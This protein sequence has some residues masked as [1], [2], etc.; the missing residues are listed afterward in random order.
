MLDATIVRARVYA[1][2]AP[3]KAETN[4]LVDREAGGVRKSTR[5]ATDSATR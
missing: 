2:E 4:S 5:C 1:A 3:K